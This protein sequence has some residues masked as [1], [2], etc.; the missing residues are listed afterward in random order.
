[1][2][3]TWRGI[4]PSLTLTAWILVAAGCSSSSSPSEPVGRPPWLQAL[5]AQIEREPV[6]NPP[7][8]IFRYRYQ[9]RAVYFRP[10]RCCDI[11]SELYD[12]AGRL[13]C[14][15]DGG[16]TGRG[17][18]RCPDFFTARSDEHLIWRDPRPS[19]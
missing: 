16:I 14:H 18:G 17:D 15:P 1:M 10:A 6:T 3:R 19:S 12:D 13:I 2:A 5:I 11:Q 9:S 8:A 7:S 4:A